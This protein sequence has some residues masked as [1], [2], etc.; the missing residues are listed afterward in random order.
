MITITTPTPLLADL[1]DAISTLRSALHSVQRDDRYADPGRAADLT[2][3][4]DALERYRQ[5]VC[6]RND[7]DYRIGAEPTTPT[8]AHEAGEAVGA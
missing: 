4:I 3:A 8:V 2:A 6:N 7:P 5:A 1:D